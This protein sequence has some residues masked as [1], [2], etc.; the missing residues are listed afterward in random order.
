VARH[1]C[2]MRECAVR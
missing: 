1:F 2:A